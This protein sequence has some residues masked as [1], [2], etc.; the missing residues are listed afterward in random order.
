[1]TKITGAVWPDRSAYL[2]RGSECLR[3]VPGLPEVEAGYPRP[4]AEEFPGMFDADLDAVVTWP[5]GKAYFF[6]GA[7][8]TR[9]DLVGGQVD[10]GY[11]QPIA[12]AWSGFDQ[13]GFGADLDALAVWP[14]G[15]AYVFKGDQYLRY[16]VATDMVDAG[17][18]RAI[19]EAWPGIFPSDLDAFLVVDNKAY[20]V[21]GEEYVRYDI[22][23][24]LSDEGFPQPIAGTWLGAFGSEA[25]VPG[26]EALFSFEP[27]PGESE[28]DRIVRC[29]SEAL[30]EGPM[31]NLNR[32]EFYREFVSCRQEL[33]EKAAEDL[34]RT[35]TSCAVFVRAVLHWCGFSPQGPYVGATGMF[36]SM[37]N[38]S[39]GHTSF[40]RHNGSNTP[41]PGDYFYIANTS[42]GVDGHTGIFIEDL[43]GGEWRTA[44]GGG[45]GTA[46]G[47]LCRF[48]TR[49]IGTFSFEGEGR[50]LHGWFDCTKVGLPVDALASG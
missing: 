43:G 10:P 21:R 36:K 1:M 40:V 50:R 38:V 32:H 48:E 35:H 9:Y 49:R 8:Y 44:E 39:L 3:V 33:T 13:A 29:C 28:R 6:K 15:K 45:G 19:A 4:I 27:R 16:D 42:T 18:P 14:N 37:G 5:N 26:S 23:T 41:L 24:D 46:D 34:A 25:G 31:G 22:E 30:A 12:P 2:F 11:P 17:Y 47:T 20:A 7:E